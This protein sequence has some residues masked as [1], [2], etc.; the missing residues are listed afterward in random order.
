MP[1][2]CQVL[3]L[4][5]NIEYS[6]AL[7]MLNANFTFATPK[8]MCEIKMESDTIASNLNFVFYHHGFHLIISCIG[9]STAEHHY[10]T[11]IEKSS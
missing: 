6:P 8:K 1:Y 5:L 7:V 4:N 9:L 10:S 11:G 3:Y 2:T